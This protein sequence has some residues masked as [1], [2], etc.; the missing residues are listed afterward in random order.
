M[1]KNDDLRIDHKTEKY[2]NGIRESA[3]FVSHHE[4]PREIVSLF[5][6]RDGDYTVRSNES[7]SSA[8]LPLKFKTYGAAL[9]EYYKRIHKFLEYKFSVSPFT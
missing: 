1:N 6:A 4:A 8:E 3:E 2:M 9:S 5:R 7:L